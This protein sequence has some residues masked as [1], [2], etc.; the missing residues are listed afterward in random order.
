MGKRSKVQRADKSPVDD[1][2]TEI[3]PLKIIE[4]SSGVKVSE[5][6]KDTVPLRLRI[7]AR[8]IAVGSV[9]GNRYEWQRAGDVVSVDSSD[10]DVLLAKVV[11]GLCCSG[12]ENNVFELGD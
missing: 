2:S 7:P 4:V 5:I 11:R 12:T 3:K 6:G 1:E 8:Y 10:A 9:T